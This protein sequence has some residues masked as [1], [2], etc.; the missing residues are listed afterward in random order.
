MKKHAMVWGCTLVLAI[1]MQL[2][3]AGAQNP[4]A[5]QAPKAPAATTPK[6]P[7]AEAQKPATATPSD[8]PLKDQKDKISYAIGMNVGI[9]LHK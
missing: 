5:S 8:S 6:A 7:A 9:N 2:M 3:P 1:M 4:P